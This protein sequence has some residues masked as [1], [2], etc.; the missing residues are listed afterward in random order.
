MQFTLFRKILKN[1]Y[2]SAKIFH[3]PRTFTTTCVYF[4]RQTFNIGDSVQIE[5]FFTQEDVAI[6]ARLTHDDNPIHLDETV[7]IEK[8]FAKPI[9]HGALINGVI[10]SIIGTKLPGHGSILIEQ[11][12]HFPNPLFVGEKFITKVTIADRKRNIYFCRYECLTMDN[13]KVTEGMAKILFRP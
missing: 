12:L 2:L 7:A 6:F 10:S 1:V 11:D 3:R 13:K 5:R 4:N 8:N 9:V